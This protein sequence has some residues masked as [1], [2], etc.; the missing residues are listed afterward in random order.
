MH[1]HFCS[2]IRSDGEEAAL[3]EEAL[4]EEAAPAEEALAD[5]MGPKEI[6]GDITEE[7]E[8]WS[9]EGG[10]EV[11]EQCEGEENF[12]GWEGNCF[13]WRWREADYEGWDEMD[14]D[15]VVMY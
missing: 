6:P 5:E 11:R 7:S 15:W 12:D 14:R 10:Q 1:H 9:E 4:A 3:V 13:R 2:F 8:V